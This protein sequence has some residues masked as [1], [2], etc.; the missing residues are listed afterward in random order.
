MKA[1]TCCQNAMR[2]LTNSEK[3]GSLPEY[4][5]LPAAE[6]R[7]QVD[8]ELCPAFS[9]SSCSFAVIGVRCLTCG[10]RVGAEL[11]RS[12]FLHVWTCQNRCCHSKNGGQIADGSMVCARCADSALQ[13][14]EY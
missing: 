8:R 12:C 7:E 9:C 5:T 6:R 10:S 14:S 4:V 2:L 3:R 1:P 11:K 13:C